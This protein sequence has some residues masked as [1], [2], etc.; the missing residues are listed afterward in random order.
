MC[1]FRTPKL[2][3]PIGVRWGPEANIEQVVG[4]E[5][6]HGKMKKER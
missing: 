1:V 6:G 2:E 3:L 4:F 5:V